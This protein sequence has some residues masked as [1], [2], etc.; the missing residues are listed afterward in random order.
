MS[1]QHL[2]FPDIVSETGASV[3]GPRSV[4]VCDK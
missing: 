3:G 1:M 4:I 2:L